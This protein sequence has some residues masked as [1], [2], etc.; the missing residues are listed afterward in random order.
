MIKRSSQ[1]ITIL[2]PTHFL[3]FK[4]TKAHTVSVGTFIAHRNICWRLGNPCCSDCVSFPFHLSQKILFIL[5]KI[6]STFF[7]LLTLFSCS[8]HNSRFMS[9]ARRM[10]HFTQSTRRERIARR[11]EE[12]NIKRLLPVHCS[13]STH[14]HYMNFA[15]QYG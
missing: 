7:F 2:I 10:R 12:K 3:K 8:V 5:T 6:L 4:H 15:L 13:G 9:Q 11:G 1:Y 14:V